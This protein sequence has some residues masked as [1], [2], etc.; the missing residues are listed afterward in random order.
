MS[1]EGQPP[2]RHDKRYVLVQASERGLWPTLALT[3]RRLGGGKVQIIT[4]HRVFYGGRDAEPDD[5]KY[6]MVD[7]V[8]LTPGALIKIHTLSK[9]P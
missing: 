1:L 9:K 5:Y 7:S 6:S 8:I 4:W 3:A 2:W